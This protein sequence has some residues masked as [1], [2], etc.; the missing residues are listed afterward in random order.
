MLKSCWD[1]ANGKYYLASENPWPTQVQKIK[2]QPRQKT[3]PFTAAEVKAILTGFKSDRYYSHYADVVAFLFG[4]GC[5][6][7]EAFG[8]RWR[9]ISD[10]FETCWIGES[11]SRGVRKSTKTGK[12]RT[13]LLGGSVQEI[14][15]ARYLQLQPKPDDLV[16]PAPKGGPINDRLFN[17]RA[18]HTV[19][20]RCN[21]EYRKPYGMRHTAISHALANGAHHIQVA[22]QTGHDPRV[23]Y[24]SYASVIE[25]KSVFVEF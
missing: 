15:K 7:G 20:E 24:Q 6:P 3:K 11:V 14:L 18:W 5:R 25:S 16:F 9:H 21:I 23:L 12:A 4:V 1:W 2:P 22:E 10:N 17:R 19:L 8:L 13:I